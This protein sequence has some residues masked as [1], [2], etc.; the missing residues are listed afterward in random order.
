MQ[1]VPPPQTHPTPPQQLC[2]LQ[3]SGSSRL[4]TDAAEGH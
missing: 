4:L 2:K 1:A 3:A